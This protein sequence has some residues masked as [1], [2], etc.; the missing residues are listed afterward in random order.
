MITTQLETISPT[1]KPPRSVI[2]DCQSAQAI[3]NTMIEEDRPR[4]TLRARNKALYD[5]AAPWNPKTLREEGQANRTN[6]N[7][8]QAKAITDSSV[9]SYWDARQEVPRRVDVVLEIPG[10]TEWQAQAW[11]E[12]IA[13]GFDKLLKWWGQGYFAL[14]AKSDWNRIYH[15]GGPQYFEHADTWQPR[16]AEFGE[17][18]VPSD[19]PTDLDDN[20]IM[21]IRKSY[22]MQTLYRFIENPE[23][24]TLL[25][26]N[27][28]ACRKA[29]ELAPEKN[30]WYWDNPEKREQQLK[31]NGYFLCETQNAMIPCIHLM[32]KEFDGKISRYIMCEWGEIN[33][34]LCKPKMRY[35]SFK[36]FINPYFINT[37]EGYWHGV[38]GLGSQFYNILRI[39]DIMSCQFIDLTCISSSVLLVP[40]SE[41]D[42]KKLLSTQLGPITILPPDT[43]VQSAQFP[44]LSQNGMMVNQMLLQTLQNTTGAY[45]QRASAPDGQAMTAT[46][47][48]AN[49]ANAAKLS[50]SQQNQ[51]YT[52]ESEMGF[53]MLRRAINPNIRDDREYGRLAKKFQKYCEDHGVPKKYLHKRFIGEVRAVRASG[54]GSPAMRMMLSQQKLGMIGLITDPTLQ[55]R[56]KREAWADIFGYE[57]AARYFPD[58]PVPQTTQEFSDADGEN[59]D[60]RVGQARQV[61]PYQ[62]P[63]IHLQVHLPDMMQRYEATQNGQYNPQ[64]MWAYLSTGLPHSQ[65]HLAQ[66]AFDPTQKE[67]FKEYNDAFQQLVRL[68]NQLQQQLTDQAKAQAKEQMRQMQEMQ[69]MLEAAQ[70][71]N[72]PVELAKLQLAY[73]KQA[74][75]EMM[76]RAR[77]G[78]TAS[79]QQQQA[80]VTDIDT[81]IKVKDANTSES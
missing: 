4:S 3:V 72:D 73:Q 80:A 7:M 25:G 6:V 55:Y 81:A 9:D 28:A 46:Q 27:V 59:A 45:M 29:I 70:N 43:T 54:A 60:M 79:K 48:A 63:A 62:N 42:L 22:D 52:Q 26:W 44:N 24:A 18:L 49:I 66:M 14:C 35:E 20:R 57:S 40:R 2:A 58:Q 53:E 32:V 64:E 65:Q 61:F 71:Q 16:S 39:M 17:V 76:D 68:A 51:F 56:A 37:A 5:G 41:G 47:V 21:A 1:G 34:Y 77:L 69:K 15:G 33:E 50:T 23:Q 36:E 38:R 11:A 67:K 13:C 12:V 10:V 74:H 78:L 19:A 30:G 75:K 31:D 8:R